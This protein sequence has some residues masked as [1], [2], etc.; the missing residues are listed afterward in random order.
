MA[1]PQNTAWIEFVEDGQEANFE[2]LFETFLNKSIKEFSRNTT[3]LCAKTFKCSQTVPHHIAPWGALMDKSGSGSCAVSPDV[4]FCHTRVCT[5]ACLMHLQPCGRR[6]LGPVVCVHH[7]LSCV[8]QWLVNKLCSSLPPGHK[9]VDIH[10][11]KP[12]HALRSVLSLFVRQ[13]LRHRRD[14]LKTLRMFSG[15]LTS[16]A[17][18]TRHQ[19]PSGFLYFMHI[20]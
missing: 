4:Y 3:R 5:P 16:C 6:L 11:V 13:E 10:A 17:S 15:H 2:S 8:L 19:A 7:V 20:F 9:H 1:N 14:I 12:G 18:H